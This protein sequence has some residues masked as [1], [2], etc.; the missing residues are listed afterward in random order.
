MVDCWVIH[1]PSLDFHDAGGRGR[2]P[3]LCK[4]ASLNR[5]GADGPQA[6][7]RAIATDAHRIAWVPCD[8]FLFF[9]FLPEALKKN[10]VCPVVI[11]RSR[12]IAKC[13]FLFEQSL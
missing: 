8:D 12:Q 7:E 1:H 2:H 6:E 3:W 9:V 13:M 11:K 5:T 10:T 4:H